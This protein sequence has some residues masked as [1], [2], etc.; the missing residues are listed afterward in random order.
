MLRAS[1]W[2]V[3]SLACAPP[4]P[5]ELPRETDNDTDPPVAELHPEIRILYPDGLEPLHLDIDGMLR[6][7][8]VVDLINVEFVQPGGGADPAEGEGHWHLFV[9]ETEY[10]GAPGALHVELESDQFTAG[11]RGI[12]NVDLRQHDH[13]KYEDIDPDCVCDARIEF[14]VLAFETR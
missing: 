4:D 3:L 2:L 14:D 13:S 10:V 7:L 5:I 9:Q 1:A 12:I 8:V 11:S 6:T